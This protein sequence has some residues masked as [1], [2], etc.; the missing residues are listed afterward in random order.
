MLF[1]TYGHVIDIVC[2]KTPKMRGQAHVAFSDLT[3]ATLALKALQG[4]KFFGKNLKISYAKS[5]SHAIAKLD[6]TY[7][8]P[9]PP[10]LE[11]SKL[12][13]APFEQTPGGEGAAKRAR[14]TEEDDY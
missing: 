3:G 8:M 13:L 7:K 5:K 6:G 11:E 4:Q 14:D 12:P 1:S 9:P 10:A 2:L